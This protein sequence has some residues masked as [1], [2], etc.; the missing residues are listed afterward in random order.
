MKDE[1]RVFW[2]ADDLRRNFESGRDNNRPRRPHC[3]GSHGIEAAPRPIYSSNLHVPA[4][5]PPLCLKAGIT[6]SQVMSAP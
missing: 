5:F 1:V 6:L 4:Q 3:L 2:K